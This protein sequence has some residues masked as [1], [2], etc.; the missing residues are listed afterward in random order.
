MPRPTEA[1]IQKALARTAKN[2]KQFT[3]MLDDFADA[4]DADFEAVVRLTVLKLHK[5]ITVR[6]PVKTGVYRASHGIAVGDEP[7]EGQGIREPGSPRIM[8]FKWKI[9]DGTI[10]LYNNVPYAAVLEAGHS[11]NAPN[12]IYAVALAEFNIVLEEAMR[13]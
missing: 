4:L 6:S 3:G 12:G 9:E 13:Q 10:W 7:T 11:K 8:S 1:K 5:N 2:A